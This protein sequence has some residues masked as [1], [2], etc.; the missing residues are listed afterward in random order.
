MRMKR[1]Q[2][3]WPRWKLTQHCMV[4]LAASEGWMGSVQAAYSPHHCDGRRGHTTGITQRNASAWE[5]GLMPGFARGTVN[6][7]PGP[8]T[9]TSTRLFSVSAYS[10]T[11]SD[12]KAGIESLAPFPLHTTLPNVHDGTAAHVEVGTFDSMEDVEAGRRLMNDVIVEGKAWPFEPL[13]EDETSFRGYFLSHTAFVVRDTTTQKVLGSFY[14]KPNFPGRCSHICNGG[15][16]V[17]PSIRGHRVGTLMGSCFLLYAKQLG[18]KGSYF[19]LVFASNHASIK[20]WERLG[21]Q[22]VAAIPNAARLEGMPVDETTGEPVLDTAYGYYYNLEELP[23]D[24][25]PLDALSMT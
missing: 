25:N 8:R 14:I 19:N 4:A 11:P 23:D 13:F 10:G 20:L 12:G 5:P 6:H 17:D 21:F 15:F 9:T 16:I 7:P 2:H 3:E 22:R 1:Q 18:F 24:Y